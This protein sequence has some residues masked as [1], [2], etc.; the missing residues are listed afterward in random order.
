MEINTVWRHLECSGE[1]EILQDRGKSEAISS[2]ILSHGFSMSLDMASCLD[3]LLRVLLGDKKAYTPW[4][5]IA[6]PAQP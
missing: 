2:C 4:C 1:A 3:I 5:R 6:R